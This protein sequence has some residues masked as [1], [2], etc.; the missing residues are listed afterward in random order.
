MPVKIEDGD[1]QSLLTVRL[2][3]RD[4]VDL[5]DLAA[6]FHSLGTQFATYARAHD[7]DV[8]KD[9]IRLYVVKLSEGS[10]V[11][12]L[13]PLLEQASFIVENIDVLAGFVTQLDQ[14]I[15]YFAGKNPDYDSSKITKQQA[16]QVAGIVEPI[17]KDQGAQIN[18]NVSDKGKV[19]IN[20]N[21]Y[22][23][24]GRAAQ[25]GVRRFLNAEPLPETENFE[26]E[27]LYLHRLD[28]APDKEVDRGVIEKFDTRPRKLFFDEGI[29]A[30]ILSQ[31]ENP[32]AFGFLVNGKVHR[33]KD[34]VQAYTILEV[35]DFVELEE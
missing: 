24:D 8:A 25:D 30:Q 27:L 28:K 7:I 20:N 12:Q 34:K 14:L 35:T 19:V 21:Y 13:Q 17:A 23:P 2:E 1:L 18:I 5:I 6:S 31:G 4:P 26:G 29:K 32:F 9:N 15:W 16:I 10:I 11:A 3:N 33:A 22:S